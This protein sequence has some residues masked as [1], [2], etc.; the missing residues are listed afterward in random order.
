MAE[1]EKKSMSLP[2]KATMVDYQE[3][4]TTI[5]VQFLPANA[6]HHRVLQN[7]IK[8]ISK[9]EVVR[10]ITEGPL[11]FD[12]QLTTKKDVPVDPAQAQRIAP[13]PAVPA[14]PPAGFDASGKRT[15]HPALPAGYDAA[16]RSVAPPAAPDPLPSSADLD[17]VASDQTAADATSAPKP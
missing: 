11:S 4:T 14:P 12:V 15:S 10:V 2:V 8:N 1:V 6:N 16:G 3:K 9:V 17:S 7:L 5:R 13:V